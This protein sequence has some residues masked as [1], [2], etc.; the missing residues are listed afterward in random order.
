MITLYVWA[1][2]SQASPFAP[3]GSGVPPPL[4]GTPTGSGRVI[5]NA[6][7]TL[8]PVGQVRGAGVGEG[9][10]SATAPEGVDTADEG[11]VGLEPPQALRPATRRIART[12]GRLTRPP[13][14]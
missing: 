4:Y 10:A 6:D 5:P 3:A 12:A 14:S 9:V 7:P 2:Y 8:A 1:W 11:D 13:T